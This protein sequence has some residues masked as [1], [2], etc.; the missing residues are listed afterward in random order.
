MISQSLA[1]LGIAELQKAVLG[2]NPAIK[3]YAALAALQ[4]K[5]KS[6][7]MRQGQAMQN[8]AQ[9]PVAQQMMAQAEQ[10][11]PAQINN[12]YM[13][14]GLGAAPV[15]SP[16][17]TGMAS[18]G[19][20]A[21][22]GGGEVPRFQT[23]D[24]IEQKKREQ[25]EEDRA[26][27]FDKFSRFGTA[28]KDMI[29]LPGRAAAGV[30]NTAVVRPARA[31][32][33]ANIPYLFESTPD[34]L[35]SATPFYDEKYNKPEEERKKAEA[36]WAK[37]AEEIKKKAELEDAR[38]MVDASK[39]ETASTKT[40][41]TVAGATSTTASAAKDKKE[42]TSAK[43]KED[44]VGIAQAAASKDRYKVNPQYA[45]MEEFMA[46]RKA[47]ETGADK[48]PEDEFT[49]LQKENLTKREA[50]LAKTEEKG[51]QLAYLQAAGPFFGPGNLLQNAQRGLP[52][53]AEAKI[54]ANS[55]LDAA[56]E[57]VMDA[58]DAYARYNQ[59]RQDNN[60]KDMRDAFK[61]FNVYTN[62]A[63]MLKLT[64][65]K[66]EDTARYQDVAGKA[67]LMTANAAQ[68]RAGALAN[69]DKGALTQ[70][71]QGKLLDMANDNVQKLLETN[72]GLKAMI[73]A[74]KAAKEAGRPFDPIAY[75]NQLVQD[76]I[77]KLQPRMAGGNT[78]GP[79]SP[80]GG[81][82]GARFLGFE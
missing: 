60:K 7:Q 50:R 8:P 43:S 26:S 70:F 61:D 74:Q 35:N 40:N 64:A 20:V 72:L 6:E 44:P 53:F 28:A 29:S 79:A 14:S 45:T 22:D 15:Q 42:A 30:L 19:I 46:A 59:A 12:P 16:V 49:K 39:G 10:L 32:T 69:Y 75:R 47:A 3:P 38:Q 56:Q 81:G 25:L 57:K 24:L 82:S 62:Q 65:T 71:Q 33:G 23:G 17:Q 9:P 13:A 34:Y 48:L 73:N 68:T 37:D 51:N 66:A 41:K 4:E 27:L 11:N 80:A 76:E 18:G 31:L 54:K 21:F 55:L 36:G 67:A 5:V 2:M 58:Q 52:A 1:H 63:E 78:M 77:Q